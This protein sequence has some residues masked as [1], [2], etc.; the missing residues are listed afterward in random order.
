MARTPK[1]N[2]LQ[3]ILLSTAFAREDGNVFPLAECIANNSERSVA[4]LFGS[5]SSRG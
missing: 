1:L 5:C 4:P 3:L 2:G